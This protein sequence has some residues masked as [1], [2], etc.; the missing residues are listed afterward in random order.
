MRRRVEQ[1]RFIYHFSPRS[2]DKKDAFFH[3]LERLRIDQFFRMLIERH[4]HRY[5]VYLPKYGRELFH[6]DLQFFQDG[7]FN[8]NNIKSN[9]ASATAQQF[10]SHQ[11]PDVSEA[12]NPD[13]F[14]FQFRK[15]RLLAQQGKQE[16][17]R[18]LSHAVGIA[19]WAVHQFYFFPLQLFYSDII[20]PDA[21][22]DDAA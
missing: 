8:R 11:F 12:D 14:A 22:A 17:Q 2:I 7:R 9:H 18:M 6:L 4:M 15:W 1:C 13:S 19:A 3:L 16:I 20:Q 10:P 21:A 5:Y